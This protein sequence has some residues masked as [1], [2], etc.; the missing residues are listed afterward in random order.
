MDYEPWNG[1]RSGRKKGY[2]C[3]QVQIMIQK[4]TT[5]VYKRE[6]ETLRQKK[7]IL[8]KRYS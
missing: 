2:R 1:D 7:E 3:Y 6:R 8:R 4:K 5:T